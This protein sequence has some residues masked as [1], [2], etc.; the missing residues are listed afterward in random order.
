MGDLLISILAVSL[1]FVAPYE[2][3]KTG[4]WLK[5]IRLE[6]GG[7]PTNLLSFMAHHDSD[8]CDVPA[9]DHAASDLR[10]GDDPQAICVLL[11]LAEEYERMKEPY[12]CNYLLTDGRP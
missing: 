11:Y 3:T 9:I 2:L 6:A 8:D 4:L 12:Q 7:C 10:N 1:A 5:K